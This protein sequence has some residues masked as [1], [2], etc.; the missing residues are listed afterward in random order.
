MLPL[1]PSQVTDRLSSIVDPYL[2]CDLV[3]AK[4]VQ[5]IAVVGSTI[6]I[7][8]NFLYPASK[9]IDTI[10]SMIKEV[11]GSAWPDRETEIKSTWRVA[12]HKVQ[13]DLK[14]K[15]GVKNIIAVGSGK[16]GVGKSTVSLHLALALKALGAKVA[17]LDADIYGP[18]QPRMLGRQSTQAHTYQ[19]QLI[20][21]ESHGIESMSVGYLV[22][23]DTPMIWR[24]PM[25]SGALMQM[26]NETAWSDCDYM[27]VD[28]P[29][30]TGDIQLTMAQKLPIAGAVIVTTPQDIALIDAK[31]A[32]KMFEKVDIPVL[33]I[34]E[35][36][37]FHTC[38]QC[39]HHDPIFGTGGAE[40]IEAA[41]GKPLL[42]QLPLDVRIQQACESNKPLIISEPDSPITQPF[43][44]MA[45]KIAG[46][47]AKQPIDYAAAMPKI[48]VTA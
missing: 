43:W 11:C 29:P 6:Q 16:G 23:Q 18:S 36:M 22:D 39:G 34:V 38:S 21:V 33:G 1:L 15:S 41:F 13:G 2:D 24:G 48:S 27:I 20:P 17:I 7:K 31:K 32:S 30:G 37:G 25:V 40:K 8:L 45:Q 4:I 3:T 19:K 47:L 28:L 42:A 12:R 9:Q 10:E 35:N 46:R 44:E 26:L 14:H 5:E